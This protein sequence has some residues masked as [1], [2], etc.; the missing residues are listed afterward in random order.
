M[1]DAVRYV[2]QPLLGFL[3]EFPDQDMLLDA[4]RRA[5]EAGYSSIDT[6]SPYP[7]EGMAEVLGIETHNIGWLS[8]AGGLFGFF[9]TLLLQLFTNW[10]YPINVGGRPL[11]PFTAFTVID[12]EL[13]VLFA[14]LFPVIGMLYLNGLP[15]LHHPLFGTPRFSL[16]TD[17]RFFLYIDASDPKFDPDRT[18]TFLGSL[19][20]WTIQPV[21]E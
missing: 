9:G 21:V 16:A 4:A 3:A 13:M 10:D 12:Y 6:F 20:A 18:D 11:Y 5:R 7:V 14:V 8:V 1:D 2:D 17:D 19:G 15:R